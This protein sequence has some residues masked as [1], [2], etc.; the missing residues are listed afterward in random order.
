MRRGKAELGVLTGELL[1][2][3]SLGM[4]LKSH[5]KQK[6]LKKPRGVDQLSAAT[7]RSILVTRPSIG[8]RSSV[9]TSSRLSDTHH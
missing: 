1:L 3:S 9:T 6:E 7:P 8:L 5:M 4:K 2:L